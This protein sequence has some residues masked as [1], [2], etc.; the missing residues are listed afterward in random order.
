[1]LSLK[2]VIDQKTKQWVKPHYKSLF[3]WFLFTSSNQIAFL[4]VLSKRSPFVTPSLRKSL[5][6]FIVQFNKSRSCVLVVICFHR[7]TDTFNIML[8]HKRTR[9]GHRRFSGICWIFFNHVTLSW[10][11]PCHFNMLYHEIV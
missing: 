5:K 1:M 10:I 4:F 7:N 3:L 2:L 8:W 11:Q 9:I 6:Y